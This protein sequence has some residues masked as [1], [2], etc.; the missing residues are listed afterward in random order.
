MARWSIV[1]MIL[2]GIAGSVSSTTKKLFECRANLNAALKNESV[3]LTKI[4]QADY[5]F[6]GKIKE[7]RA[8]ELHVR[9]KR[10]IKG[11]LN[12]TMILVLN[13]TCESYLRRS[14]TGIFMAR[15]IHSS[16]NSHNSGKIFM[17][18]GPIS[19]TLMNLDKINAAI[20]GMHTNHIC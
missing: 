5:I 2:L 10:A 16:E 11:N 13:D 3:F 6:T 8:N 7:L 18:F 1:L 20:R 17:N 15:R 19:L 9:V 14:F 12:S 4:H